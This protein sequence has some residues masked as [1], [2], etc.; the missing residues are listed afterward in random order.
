MNSIDILRVFVICFGVVWRALPTSS[1][2]VHLLVLSRSWRRITRT[3]M[4]ATDRGNIQAV[5]DALNSLQQYDK[6]YIE[7][8]KQVK[9]GSC[10]PKQVEFRRSQSLKVTNIL[11]ILVFSATDPNQ[12]TACSLPCTQIWRFPSNYWQGRWNPQ[13]AW[14]TPSIDP[15]YYQF[16]QGCDTGHQDRNWVEG[17][18]GIL[19]LSQFFSLTQDFSAH[20]SFDIYPNA[21]PP[22][23]IPSRPH[24]LIFTPKVL[25]AWVNHLELP[26]G[27]LLSVNENNE[28]VENDA[29][30]EVKTHLSNIS[31]P[32]LSKS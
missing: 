16:F 1:F 23:S 31:I 7:R 11:R 14:K 21:I 18:G 2:R 4:Q 6:E 22:H 29:W 27:R 10:T 26:R 19:L 12:C 15:W 20:Q 28:P 30:S 9:T 32:L 25:K 5:E 13:G 8:M 24:L 17:C 3:K